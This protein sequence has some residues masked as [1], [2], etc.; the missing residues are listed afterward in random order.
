MAGSELDEKRKRAEAALR[1]SEERY[2]S[3]VESTYD[4]IYTVNRE[5][6]Y[7]FANEKMLSVLGLPL[8]KVVGRHYSAFLSGESAKEFDEKV[9]Q[10][11]ENG[12]P[13]TYECRSKG[14]V[15]LLRTLSLIKDPETGEISAVTGITKSITE[16][17]QAGEALQKERDMAQMYLDIAGVALV[18]IDA[19]QKV[20][21]I[22]KKGCD[23]LGYNENE[24]I[25]KNWFDSFI[26][27]R[28]RAEVKAVFDK[29]MT[30]EIEPVEYF[31]NSVLT[32]SGEEKL[33]AWHNAPLKDEK[34]KILATI[35]SG[36]DITERKRAEDQI[37]A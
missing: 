3:L 18:V 25:G 27:E 22:N 9:K 4:S 24:I 8:E 28:D 31:E 20:S 10:V 34:G 11:F 7:L 21:L 17:K 2:R 26:V 23:I 36:E 35:S 33:I 30:G 32:K 14:D 5:G 12:K 13:V 1:A 15:W 16:L 29:L 6:K 19:D 37:K